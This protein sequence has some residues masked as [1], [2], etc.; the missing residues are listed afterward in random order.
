MFY[1]KD[2][3]QC[4]LYTFGTFSQ[5]FGISNSKYFKPD[6][7]INTFKNYVSQIDNKLKIKN[8]TGKFNYFIFKTF[9]LF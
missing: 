6:Q 7:N 2:N 4:L 9:L 5:L 8:N 1:L 3:S